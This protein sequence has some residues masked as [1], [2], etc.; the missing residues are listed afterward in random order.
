MVKD[1]WCKMDE[2]KRLNDELRREISQIK[3]ADREIFRQCKARWNSI[4]KPLNGLGRLE[5]L[6]CQIGAVRQDMDA[7][8]KKK[9]A[10]IFCADN[11]VVCEGV[12]QTDE[13]VTAIVAENLAEGRANVNLMGRISDVTVIPV[14]IGMK[15]K[16]CH[17]GVLDF[18]VRRGTD[19][20]AVGPAMKR[21]ECIQAILYG[22]EMAGYARKQGFD[23]IASGEMGIGNTTT[24]SAIASVLLGREPELVTGKGAGLSGEGLKRKV[25][26]IKRAIAVNQPNPDDPVDMIAKIGGL[27]IAGMTGLFAGGA[28]YQIPVIADGLISTISAI[29][30]TML[31]Q[32]IIGYIIP[33]HAG[34]EPACR[35]LSEKLGK[36][37]LIYADMALGEGT[38]AVSMFPLIDMAHQIYSQNITF[39][40]IN[41]EAYKPL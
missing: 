31:N 41:M 27:D 15:K 22:I 6:I 39:S 28:I 13:S 9:C 12:S 33:S 3:P 23:L 18:C 26:V 8:V 34:K 29:L 2:I 10:V 4:A 25:D 36:E 20:I 32:D 24:S 5:E 40:D 35:M 38:G 17:P 16:V 19:N 30:A 21:E 1:E 37:P 14:D 11:G 7:P